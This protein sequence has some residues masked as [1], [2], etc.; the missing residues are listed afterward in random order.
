MNTKTK[1]KI[2][3]A[4][5]G[6]VL[7]PDWHQPHDDGCPNNN[8]PMKPCTCKRPLHRK[9]YKVCR[10]HDNKVPHGISPDIIMETHPNGLLVFREK[11]R[12]TRYETTAGQIF[13]GLVRKAGYDAAA[14]K[15]QARRNKRAARRNK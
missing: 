15:R 2:V 1:R 11:G 9:P 5:S 14:A 6:V 12:R 4:S 3:T 10:V 7:P 8:D 13:A